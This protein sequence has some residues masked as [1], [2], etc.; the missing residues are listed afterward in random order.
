MF[1]YIGKGVCRN[2]NGGYQSS[3]MGDNLT[4]QKCRQACL[5]QADCDAFEVE[6]D[7]RFWCIKYQNDGSGFKTNGSGLVCYAKKKI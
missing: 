4:V 3:R 5:A 6:L 1:D 2:G 7:A